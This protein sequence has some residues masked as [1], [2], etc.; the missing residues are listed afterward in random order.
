MDLYS[1]TN[2]FIVFK[3]GD[4]VKFIPFASISMIQTTSADDD[5]IT[6]QTLDNQ[7]MTVNIQANEFYQMLLEKDKKSVDKLKDKLDKIYKTV[8]QL[9]TNMS[10]AANVTF[11]TG[12]NPP[13]FS[14]KRH[15]NQ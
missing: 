4:L 13:V 3:D 10:Q 7:T 12:T 6:I 15:K 1:I 11:P 2:D 9:Q 14:F 5:T 8:N